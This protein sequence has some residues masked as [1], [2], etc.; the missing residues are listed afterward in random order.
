VQFIHD[1]LKTAAIRWKQCR[2]RGGVLLWVVLRSVSES[3]CGGAAALLGRCLFAAW[4][5]E[6]KKRWACIRD[7]RRA[8]VEVEHVIY[9]EEWHVPIACYSIRAWWW[10][11]H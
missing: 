5:L 9:S 7:P 3:A 2:R 11:L 6:K 4:A 10:M 1:S 8:R